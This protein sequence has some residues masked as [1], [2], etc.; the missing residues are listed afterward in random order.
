METWLFKNSEILVPQFQLQSESF[1][2]HSRPFTDE[3]VIKS[4]EG[5]TCWSYSHAMYGVATLLVND[6]IEDKNLIQNWYA[7]D[8]K[9][10]GDPESLGIVL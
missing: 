2:D 7:D 3:S 5:N 8:W 4:Q 1:K 9:A 6:T 10:A